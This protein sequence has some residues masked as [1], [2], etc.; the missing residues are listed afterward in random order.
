MKKIRLTALVSAIAIYFGAATSLM[1]FSF[2]GGFSGGASYLEVTGTETLRSS[3]AEQSATEGGAGAM[4]S[5]YI[6]AQFF[7]GW[8]IGAEYIFG[9]VKIQDSSDNVTDLFAAEASESGRQLVEGIVDDFR[10]YYIETPGFTPLGIYLKA[11]YSEADVT[12]NEELVTDGTYGNGG[13]DGATWGFGFKKG[14]PD[15]GW[16]I[17]TEFNYTDWSSL[18]LNN[19]S[20]STGTSRVKVVP[21]TWTAKLGIGYNF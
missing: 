9:S 16:Q 11:G 15:G 21:E 18:T 7:G 20:D 4:P 19:D 5:A 10:T 13:I 1:A 2:G 14:D 12:T 8:T 6:Q 3:D 17:K